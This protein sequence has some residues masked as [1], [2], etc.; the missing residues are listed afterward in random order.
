M[1]N[2][3]SWYIEELAQT[4][5]RG[6]SPVGV[7]GTGAQAGSK[8]FNMALELE[9]VLG[10]PVHLVDR[11]KYCYTPYLVPRRAGFSF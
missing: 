6:I 5:R 9:D 11:E 2:S 1:R 8:F 3:R 7:L 4:E 10:R